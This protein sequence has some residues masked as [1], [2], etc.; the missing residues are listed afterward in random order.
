MNKFVVWSALI[1]AVFFLVNVEHRVGLLDKKR[2]DD[3]I[4]EYSNKFGVDALLVRSVI[5]RESDL[6][7]EA[8]SN[9]GAVGLMQIM[10]KTAREVAVELSV[11]DYSS[12]KLKDPQINIMFGAYYLRK[13]LDY[14][15]NNLILALA[16]YNAGIGNVDMWLREIPDLSV[17]AEKMPFNETKNYVKSVMFIYKIHKSISQIKI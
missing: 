12:D 1:L 3:Y 5:K 8:V 4:N 13:L 14:Y 16:A 6:N 7:P 9:K 2:Y 11:S 17:N 15:N 10:P